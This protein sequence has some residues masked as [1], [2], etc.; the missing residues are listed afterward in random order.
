M[1]NY[2]QQRSFLKKYMKVIGFLIFLHI[3]VAIINLF[4]TKTHPE[5]GIPY[6][7]EALYY[8]DLIKHMIKLLL[9]LS[10]YIPIQ[11]KNY[12]LGLGILLL[13]LA[14][15]N[16]D[17]TGVSPIPFNQHL[18]YISVSVLCLLTF[19]WMS[20]LKKSIKIVTFILGMSLSLI[21]FFVDNSNDQ[22]PRSTFILIE[23]VFFVQ[24]F[25]ATY[26]AVLL[27]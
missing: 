23:Y 16:E 9:L 22:W 2:L 19:I 1:Q 17:I 20:N 21:F 25:I 6:I 8:D 10:L 4:R 12:S 14:F 24:L 15:N 7:S 18:F 11:I 27:S 5:R 13:F 3:F 26:Q